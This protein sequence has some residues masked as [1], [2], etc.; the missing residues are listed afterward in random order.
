LPRLSTPKFDQFGEEEM[1]EGEK[2]AFTKMV[3]NSPP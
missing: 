3:E 1:D 2:E